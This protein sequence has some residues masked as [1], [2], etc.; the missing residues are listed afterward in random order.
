MKKNLSKT[1]LTGILLSLLLATLVVFTGCGGGPE[2]LEEYIDSNDEA[3]EMIDSYSSSSSDGSGMSVDVTDNTI[4]YT[5]KY[6]Q[7]FDDDVLEQ[8]KTQLE[9][10]M[11]SSSSSFSS[12]GDT[13][14]EESGLENIVV[15]VVY[16]D[17]ND[18][19]IFSAE[20]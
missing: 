19:E 13:L 18:T 10:A 1:L 7:T 12:I 9:S 3:K 15:R 5:Y 6:S 8:M 2:T 4:T 11:E 20:Y 16:L 17:G 14:E